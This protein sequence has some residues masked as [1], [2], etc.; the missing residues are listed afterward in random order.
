MCYGER[1]FCIIF[2]NF[3]VET[4]ATLVA[5]CE[6]SCYGPQVSD[7]FGTGAGFSAIRDLEI[8]N[9]GY[10][11]AADSY[12]NAIRKISSNGDVI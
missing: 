12:N 10:I 7:G 9:L 1:I 6:K 3:I 8:D 11:L 2:D 5:G 4:I